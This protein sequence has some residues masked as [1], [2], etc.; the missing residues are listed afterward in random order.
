MVAAAGHS[1]SLQ[2]GVTGQPA[3]SVR[4]FREEGGEVVSDEVNGVSGELVISSVELADA[5]NYYC[6]ASNA[7]GSVRSL[8]TSLD[9]AGI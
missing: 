2:C 6:T 9:L 8:S 1:V 4:W 5:G 7:V 3:P